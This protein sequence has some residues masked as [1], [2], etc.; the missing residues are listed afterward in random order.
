VVTTFFAGLGEQLGCGELK[1][2]AL[3]VNRIMTTDAL[4]IGDSTSRCSHFG[5]IPRQHRVPFL[6]GP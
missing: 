1:E 2:P 4:P 3:P 5:L 6:N